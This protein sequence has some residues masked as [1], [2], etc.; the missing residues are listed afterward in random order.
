MISLKESRK[1]RLLVIFAAVCLLQLT[2]GA[3]E[4]KPDKYNEFGGDDPQIAIELAIV[5]EPRGRQC[6]YQYIRKGSELKFS[7]TVQTPSTAITT[8]AISSYIR[9]PFENQVFAT[10]LED[11]V[12]IPPF[13]IKN[14]GVYEFCFN[15]FIGRFLYKKTEFFIGIINPTRVFKKMDVL[16]ETLQVYDGLTDRVRGISSTIFHVEH[17]M[18]F[19]RRLEGADLA[20]LEQNLQY[21]N[22]MSALTIVG[23]IAVAYMQILILKRFFREPKITGKAKPRA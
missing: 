2:Q 8:N 11:K 14:E 6:F 21:I 9:D 7:Y 23:V 17:Q 18:Y 22:R 16:N 19:M 20:Y 15:N 3:D 5:L 13:E 12:D 10:H 4:Q 1:F